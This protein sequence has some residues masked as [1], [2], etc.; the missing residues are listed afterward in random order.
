MPEST[1]KCVVLLDPNTRA[2]KPINHNLNANL[3]VEQFSADP[4]AKIVD[5]AGHHRSSEPRRCKPCKLAAEEATKQHAESSSETEQ[6]EQG[7]AAV[8]TEESESD[9]KRKYCRHHC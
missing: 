2:Y 1:L 7:P 4:N 9:G 3:A 6:S 5:Q 8:S